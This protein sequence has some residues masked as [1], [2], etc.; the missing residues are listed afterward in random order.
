MYPI[1]TCVKML[2][3]RVGRFILGKEP[4]THRIEGCLCP[5][6][7]LN[8]GTKTKTC[9]PCWEMKPASVVQLQDALSSVN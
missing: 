8:T 2:A 1:E 7:R 9:C 5:R 6:F 3:S 4:G